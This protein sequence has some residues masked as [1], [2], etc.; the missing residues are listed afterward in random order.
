M[1]RP[2]LF[3]CHSLGGIVMK[4]AMIIA[5]ERLMLYKSLLHSVKA[6]IFFGV[7]H[8]GADIAYWGR[9]VANL[10]DYGQLGLKVNKNLIDA[11][12]KNSPTLANISRQFVERGTQLQIRTFF[13]TEKMGNQVIV[14]ED[15]ATLHLPNETPVGIDGTNH[16]TM[17]KF[18]DAESPKYRQVWVAVKNLVISVALTSSFIE[19]PT[20]SLEQ[21]L[22]RIAGTCEWF[23]KHEKYQTWFQEPG[24][25]LLWLSADP[26]CGKSVLASWITDKL[27]A[28]SKNSAS[29]SC[30]TCY[31]F[32]KDDS[33]EQ[34][35]AVLALR[36]LLHQLFSAKPHL[37]EHAMLIYNTR[38]SKFVNEFESLWKIL[39]SA[40][41]DPGSGNI[42]C[43]IDALD[44]CGVSTRNQLI[45]SLVQLYS[46]QSV[47]NHISLKVLVTSRPYREIERNF[48][49]LPTIRLKGEDELAS[50]DNDIKLVVRDK[51]REIGRDKG[52]SED[53][54]GELTQKLI[55]SADHS[56]LWV[57]LILYFID[58]E[59]QASK[60][61]LE[62]YLRDIPSTLDEVYENMLSKAGSDNP[63]TRKILYIVVGAARP[64]S[65]TEMNFAFS[66]KGHHSSE[67][68]LKESLEPSIQNT[69]KGL[70][71]LF[72]RIIDKR[73]YL[74]HQT[75]REFL[76]KLPED[77]SHLSPP[78]KHSIS[79]YE[80]NRVLAEIC[81]R[82][83]FLSNFQ[84]Q[85]LSWEVERRIKSDTFSHSLFDYATSYWPGHFK[86]V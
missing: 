11:L 3:I 68:N 72:V 2:V 59:H 43:V 82:Y 51:V 63:Q 73:V 76:I 60:P 77:P 12:V 8:R 28:L 74:V 50:T 58:K 66:I 47:A 9:F 1:N 5:N 19:P 56:F 85:A 70:C 80:S 57:S 33:D 62:K 44:E 7:P 81:L 39:I 37:L 46:D 21:V 78:W 69:I 79:L 35:S 15:S 17:C 71:G 29:L 75:A 52:L 14:D 32:F 27:S 13:E 24:G 38:D 34:K 49:E 31:F 22:H 55:R 40:A 10:L 6:C 54:C 23:S 36:A 48:K 61:A 42:Y 41:K 20:L 45:R 67:E 16:K 65:L 53:V 64:L 84:N 30:K 83:I 18:D 25:S 26:G 86:E 4:K